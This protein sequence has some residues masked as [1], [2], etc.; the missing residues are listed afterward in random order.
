MIKI[1]IAEDQ[2]ML[3]DSL[4]F[5]IG[6][7]ADM[8]VVGTTAAAAKI[9]ELCLSLKPDLV[10]LDVVMED[11]LSGIKMAAKIRQDFPKIKIV[12]MTGLP[13]ITFL[14][15]AKKAGVHSYI[16]K[17]A[18]NE[19]LFYT[20]RSTM[21]GQ[22]IYPGH[23]DSELFAAQFTE[24][25]ISVI[26]LVCLGLS[27]SDIAKELDISEAMLKP[28]VTSILDKTGFDSIIKFAMYAVSRGLIVPPNN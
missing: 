9:P 28:L 15:E 17:N 23:T 19:H 6:N 16:Q 2:L 1:L 11:N 7:Q 13:E 25:E 8:K 26:R 18:G 5:V 4:E 14:D 10:L 22:G 27:R 21:K 24:K 20:I 3:R 12:I